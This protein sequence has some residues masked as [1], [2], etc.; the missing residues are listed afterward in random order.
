MSLQKKTIFALLPIL[1]TLS[2]VPFANAIVDESDFAL[3]LTQDVYTYPDHLQYTIW[4]Y[5]EHNQTF[6]IDYLDPDDLVTQTYTYMQHGGYGHEYTHYFSTD[7][8]EGTWTVRVT[9]PD[10]EIKKAY[11]IF[12]S[13]A[14]TLEMQDESYSFGETP[15]LKIINSHASN[16]F[17]GIIVFDQE[18]QVYFQEFELV[19][20]DSNKIISLELDAEPW[21]DSGVYFVYV[22]NEIGSQLTSFVYWN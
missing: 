14:Y 19:N 2:I 1:F 7:D 10:G 17:F 5:A 11:F 4:N 15:E 22:W 6:T 12:K 18:Q 8:K 3:E 13:P 9:N 16:P 21:M 20:P